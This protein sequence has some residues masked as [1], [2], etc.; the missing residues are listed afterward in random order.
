V[1][2][3]VNSVHTLNVKLML[4]ALCNLVV[5]VVSFNYGI[6]SSYKTRSD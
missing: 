2:E 3:T 6:V 4:V 5:T 1:N